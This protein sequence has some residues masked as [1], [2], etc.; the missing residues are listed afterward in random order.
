M[1]P[2]GNPRQPGYDEF[3][4]MSE[5]RAPKAVGFARQIIETSRPYLSKPV[6]DLDV[7]DIGSGYGHTAVELARKCRSVVGMEPA[8]DLLKSATCLA[9]SAGLSNLAF[10]LQDV[11]DLAEENTY[12]LVILD[13]V[14]EH[15]PDQRQ[16]LNSISRSLRTGGVIFLLT[17][18]KLWPIEAHYRLPFLS[19]LPLRLANRYL[20]WSRRG[21]DYTDASY[22]PT[23]L[24]LRH[25]LAA[26][27]ELSWRFTLPGD[28]TAT[29]AGSP[30]HYRVGMRLLARY[31]MFWMISKSLMVIAVKH[32]Q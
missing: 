23:W 9:N 12:D 19:Y 32:E 26:H 18:N 24:S 15:L 10:R 28:W 7:L 25:A 13:N 27:D 5:V 14:Y 8:T 3:R 4:R 11:A 29:M 20:A 16:A 31:P 2:H 1:D 6:E 22:A 30:L 17:P 21:T